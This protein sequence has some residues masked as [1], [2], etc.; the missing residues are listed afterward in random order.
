MKQIAFLV[1][2]LAGLATAQEVSKFKVFGFADFQTET[3]LYDHSFNKTVVGQDTN[4]IRLGHANLYFDFKPNNNL[5]GLVEVGFAQQDNID[6]YNVVSPYGNA[7]T[8]AAI[9]DGNGHA[10]TDDQI[11]DILT[12][13]QLQQLIEENDIPSAQ[14]EAFAN[15]QRSTVRAGVVSA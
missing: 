12:E 3:Y 1:F 2:M 6:K 4:L 7:M 13:N 5:Q 10:M 11:I 15:A 9:M 14:Q 8:Q